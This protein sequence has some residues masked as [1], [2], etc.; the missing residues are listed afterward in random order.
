M[1]IL[2]VIGNTWESEA[3][4][5]FNI[6]SAFLK[7]HLLSGSKQAFFTFDFFLVYLYNKYNLGMLKLVTTNQGGDTHNWIS[8]DYY[9]L[10]KMITFL[11][12]G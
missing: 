7:R 8:P 4:V 1:R 5:W 11:H 12:D 10:V 6:L 2:H 3:R 9:R